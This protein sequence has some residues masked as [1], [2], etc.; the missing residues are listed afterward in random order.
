MIYEQGKIPDQCRPNSSDAT[1]YIKS[2]SG[3]LEA[4]YEAHC[5]EHASGTEAAVQMRAGEVQV[6][7]G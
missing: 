7:L 3:V 4:I 5:L 2:M 1:G 6:T